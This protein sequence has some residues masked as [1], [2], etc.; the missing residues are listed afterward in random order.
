[1]ADTLGSAGNGRGWNNDLDRA[2]AFI[3]VLDGQERL[4]VGSE[5]EDK[6]ARPLCAVEHGPRFDFDTENWVVEDDTVAFTCKDDGKDAGPVSPTL[7]AMP[8]DASHA[9]GGGQVAVAYTVHGENSTAM[10]GGGDADVAFESERTRSLDTTGCYATNQGGTVVA[11]TLDEPC[12]VC[13]DGPCPHGCFEGEP[14]SVHNGEDALWQQGR[15]AALTDS[16]SQTQAVCIHRDAMSRDGISLT[17]SHNYPGDIPR[18]RDAGIG[19]RDDDQSYTLDA[20]GPHA[21][22]APY[23]KVHR[24]T[25]PDDYE[26][27]A[28]AEVANTLNGFDGSNV[29]TT[30][31]VVHDDPSLT[32]RR[33]TPLECERLQ[34]FPDEWTDGES[35]SARYRMLGNAVAVPV[36]RWLATRL[37]PV[38]ERLKEAA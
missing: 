33:L 32:V 5:W 17:E 38:A 19:I 9:N 4:F 35:D 27:W 3:P 25:S 2:G 18:K 24:A 16:R 26:S 23:R 10:T 14:F 7:R 31:A 22:A 12:E 1:M 8:H 11:Q 6:T 28:D 15:T 13:G 30:Q 37:R 20:T 21:V 29:R 36:A 34:G